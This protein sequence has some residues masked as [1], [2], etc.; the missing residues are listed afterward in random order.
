MKTPSTR[1]SPA[2]TMKDLQNAILKIKKE[3]STTVPERFSMNKVLLEYKFH[4]C[5][6]EAITDLKYIKTEPLI[7]NLKA[8]QWIWGTKD[9]D[10]EGIYRDYCNKQAKQKRDW[11]DNN[12]KKEAPHVVTVVKHKEMPAIAKA[13]TYRPG[14]DDNLKAIKGTIFGYKQLKFMKTLFRIDP[15]T[16]IIDDKF[17][18]EN[19]TIIEFCVDTEKA[20]QLTIK[21]FMYADVHKGADTSS[22]VGSMRVDNT[23]LAFTD[24]ASDQLTIKTVPVTN[25]YDIK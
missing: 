3:T 5:L 17:I 20:S 11:K 14:S 15:T 7:G 2:T 6:V 12:K 16:V 4:T 21:F 9:I 19:V 10:F 22:M 1:R 18:Y 8:Y 24:A 23:V 13:S 25:P